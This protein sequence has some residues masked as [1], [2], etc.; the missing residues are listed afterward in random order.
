M[1]KFLRGRLKVVT[2]CG[3]SLATVSG[4]VGCGTQ[5]NKP[6]TITVW[7]YGNYVV[8]PQIAQEF[9]SQH[10]G[11]HLVFSP[12]PLPPGQSSYAFVTGKLIASELSGTAPNIILNDQT[13]TAGWA[14]KNL[15]VSLNPYLKQI[16]VSKQDYP[17]GAWASAM[18]QKNVYG[19]PVDWDPDNMLY[20]NIDLMKK[21]GISSP[22]K[23]FNVLWT[24]AKKLTVK[25]G[26]SYTQMGFIPWEG[27]GFNV[28]GWAHLYGGT[29]QS[30]N[31][32]I[33]LNSPAMLKSVTWEQQWAK[34]YGPNA[35]GNFLSATPNGMDPFVDGKLAFMVTGDW[36]LP[37][38][39]K[40]AP[41]FKFG[42]D[43]G[44]ATAPVPAGGT[45]DY[46][47]SGWSWVVP[48]KVPHLQETLKVIQWLSEPQHNADW[49]IGTGWI[50]ASNPVLKQ[51]TPMLIKKDPGFEPFIE[52]RNLHPNLTPEFPATNNAETVE[53]EGTSAENEV[54]TLTSS[55]KAALNK[56]QTRAKSGI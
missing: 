16:G 46:L 9:N 37:S 5:A 42:K 39:Q 53:I 32:T 25:K 23:T 18:Y 22:P 1:N 44:V 11:I 27:Y 43:W 49:C 55:P 6:V 29:P 26:K 30:P 15:L 48:K 2:Y 51:A 28:F 31:G 36:E 17:S 14:S 52:E 4:L 47:A 7:T 10:P 35:I 45:T 33:L 34:Q 24:D 41:N 21:A 12:I 56:A 3:L 19:A 38:L 13:T 8:A 50:P 20:Y 54:T 40:Y